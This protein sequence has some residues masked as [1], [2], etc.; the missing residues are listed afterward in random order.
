MADP[1]KIQAI[2]TLKNMMMIYYLGAKNADANNR[3]IGWIT[4]GGPVELLLAFDIIPI[5]PENH[6]AM[7]GASKMG[8]QLCGIAEGLGF[9]PDLCA[10]FRADVGQAESGISPIAGLPKPD[11][12]VCSNNICKTV[13]K[14]YEIQARRYNA[15]MVMVDHPFMEGAIEP[16]AVQYVAQQLREMVPTLESIT[17]T[18][19]DEEKLFQVLLRSR[20][21]ILTWEKCLDTLKTKPTPMS[22]ID[23]FF[24][25]AP[26]VTLR[27]EQQT[28]D[29]Y[30]ELQVELEQRVAEGV[31]AVDGERHRLLFDNI[32][33]WYATKHLY[34][35]LAEYG[36]A[37]VTST[38]TASWG[39]ERDMTEG[40]PFEAMAENYL[41][42]YINRGFEKRVDI[43][44]GLMN[45]FGCDGFIMHSARSCK[46]YSLGQ[47]DLAAELTRRTGKQGVVIEG[48]IAD[49]RMYSEGQF[50]SRLE[51]YLEA[52]DG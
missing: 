15:P 48:D 10:Y 50:N 11:L 18:K 47:Y 26:I 32:P 46:A 21:A 44:E 1:K 22:S 3:K 40:D 41:A 16:T 17:G 25:M 36:A 14:W 31:A 27:G 43:L 13:T 33:M 35:K 24:H 34:Q 19:L 20:E 42:P 5:Y 4:S 28:V 23:S 45:D 51:A 30:K 2:K 49:E 38:Y 29:Y 39:M 8:G 12:L 37:V 52:L 9:S 6:G 7:V